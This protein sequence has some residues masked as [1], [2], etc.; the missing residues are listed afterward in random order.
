[1]FSGNGD[2]LLL[3]TIYVEGGEKMKQRKKWLVIALAA[4]IL[5]TIA[6][7]AAMAASPQSPADSGQV[8]LNKLAG[9]LGI[10]RAKLDAALKTAANQTVGQALQEGQITQQQADQMRSRISQGFPFFGM[11]IGGGKNGAGGGFK[12]TLKPLAD[13]LGM[14][15]QDVISALRSGKKVSDLAASKGMT[16]AQ[17]QDKMLAAIKTR[18]DQAVKSGKLTQTQASQAYSKLQQNITSGS[19]INQLQ[20][21]CQGLQDRNQ[22]QPQQQAS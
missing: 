5:G 9:A 17:V 21:C 15:P 12:V 22:S 14:A 18:L 3:K 19:W 20:N 7:G 8:F 11:K 2:T 10:D 16:V 6:A 1:L 13:V 4:A